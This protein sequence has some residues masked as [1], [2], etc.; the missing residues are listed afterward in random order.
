MGPKQHK[1]PSH[2]TNLESAVSKLIYSHIGP[3]KFLLVE[4]AQQVCPTSGKL[5]KFN[6]VVLISLGSGRKGPFLPAPQPKLDSRISDPIDWE[7]ELCLVSIANRER[8]GHLFSAGTW[9]MAV[10]KA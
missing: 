6:I 8:W 9:V 2:I 10:K 4:A 5:T 3:V 1:N 7:K